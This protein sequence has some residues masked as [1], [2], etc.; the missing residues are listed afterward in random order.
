MKARGKREARRP[1]P[2]RPRHPGLKRRNIGQLSFD[3]YQ[4]VIFFIVQ[5]QVLPATPI[6]FE[7][8]LNWG[9][10]LLLSPA[11]RK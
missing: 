3:I 7:A 2:P 10:E 1:W 6:D 11:V 5:D 8:L 9:V 4:L